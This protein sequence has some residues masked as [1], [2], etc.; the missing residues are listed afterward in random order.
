MSGPHGGEQARFFADD[1]RRINL[2]YQQ[3]CPRCQA[4]PGTLCMDPSGQVWYQLHPDRIALVANREID[5]E[6]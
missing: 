2:G 1:Q 6:P 4:E 5:G 3:Q